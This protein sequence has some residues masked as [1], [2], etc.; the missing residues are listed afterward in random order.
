MVTGPRVGA[1]SLL[2]IVE[3]YSFITKFD[4]KKRKTKWLLKLH[5]SSARSSKVRAPPFP[6]PFIFISSRTSQLLSIQKLTTPHETGDIPSFKL[7]ESEK[8]L[9]FLDINPLSRG[10]AVSI[11]LPPSPLVLPYHFKRTPEISHH[12]LT[13]GL[14]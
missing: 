8:V 5:A 7:Y 3:L 9:A 1:S 2:F 11:Y 13:V 4:L 10:H 12:K 6:L 14:I